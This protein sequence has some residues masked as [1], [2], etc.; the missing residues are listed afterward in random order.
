MPTQTLQAE[1]AA[2]FNMA[3]LR[4]MLARLGV[5]WE[6]V[7]TADDTVDEAAMAIVEWAKRR[8]RLCD[9]AGA[10]AEERPNNAILQTVARLMPAVAVSGRRVGTP[11][12]ETERSATVSYP[13]DNNEANVHQALGNFGARLSALE[14]GQRVVIWLLVPSLAL[15]VL[16][17]GGLVLHLWRPM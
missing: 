17:L 11:S 4:L 16:T 14:S 10:A 9:L 12:G 3:E 8:G 2:A 5:N 6:S 15:N 7:F 13:G 1:L